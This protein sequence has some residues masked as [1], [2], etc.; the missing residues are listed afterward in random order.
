[1]NTKTKALIATPL[2]LVAGAV[3]ALST[4]DSN[5]EARGSIDPDV[6]MRLADTY[7]NC[8]GAA[9][10]AGAL[11]LADMGRTLLVDTNPTDSEYIADGSR[12]RLTCVLGQLKT[13]Q[14]IESRIERTTAMQGVQED[15]HDG[16]AYSWTYHPDNGNEMIISLQRLIRLPDGEEAITTEEN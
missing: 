1:M 3:V 4:L 2:V 5:V 12:G 6:D 7:K 14:S 11:Q 13:P 16:I 15:S 10:D 8:K 9:G